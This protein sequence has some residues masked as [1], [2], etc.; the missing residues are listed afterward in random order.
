MLIRRVC[1]IMSNQMGNNMKIAYVS[2]SIYPYHKGGKEKRLFD[3]STRIA[4]RGHDVTIYCMK[5]WEGD[6]IRVE[7]N[8]RLAAISPLYP[9][10]KGEKR[11]IKQGILFGVHSFKLL[12]KD[13][14]VIDADHMPYFPLYTARIVCWLKGRKLIA[15]WNEVWGLVY[16]KKYLG[17]KGYIAAVLEKLTFLTPD[18][19]ISISEYT[20]KRI[21]EQ[22]YKGPIETVP[23]SVDFEAINNVAPTK[24]VSDLIYAGRLLEHKNVD[25]ML[26]AVALLIKARPDL[27]CVIV[28]DGPEKGTLEEL[29]T[30]LGIDSNVEFHGF[31]E[32]HSDVIA[33]MKS[34]K[35]FVFPSTREGFGLV[36][37]EAN[38]CGLP[39]I[40]TK[41]PDNAAKELIEEGT[42]GEL[43]DLDEVELAKAIHI[44]LE[45]EQQVDITNIQSWDE[46]IDR[47]EELYRGQ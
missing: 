37:P 34:S 38:A 16:W 21:R 11:S 36:V 7:N 12:W 17:L 35:L 28:G 2:D 18:K 47:L 42:N 27:K 24:N 10:Y 13:F 1:S 6:N 20:T 26:R 8:V 22:G 32:D 39:V 25:V 43:V 44:A 45:R 23:L 40:T 14:D 46:I 41:H 15:T 4:Q 31:L 19:I 33:R 30:S 3:V 5:W 9:L 29:A